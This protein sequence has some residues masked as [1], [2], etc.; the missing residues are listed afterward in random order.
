MTDAVVEPVDAESSISILHLAD[1][2]L[3]M[4]FACRQLDHRD[5]VAL[6]AVCSRFWAISC[7]RE[8]WKRKSLD[9]WRVWR[10][11]AV[12]SGVDWKA[13][14]HR[15]LYWQELLYPIIREVAALNFSRQD[16]SYD[17]MLPVDD[18]LRHR[19][20]DA[21]GNCAVPE[22]LSDTLGEILNS[23]GSDCDLTM[24]YYAGHVRDYVTSFQVEKDTRALCRLPA[25]EIQLEKGAILLS[26][27]QKLSTNVRPD[28]VYKQLDAMANRVHELLILQCDDTENNRHRTLRQQN[29]CCATKIPFEKSSD[30]NS[31][32]VSQSCQMFGVRSVL[33]VLNRVM[34]EEWQ[35]V[36][37]TQD[38]Y[39]PSNSYIDEVI[40]KRTGMPISLCIIY[41]AVAQRLGVRIEP[42]NFPHHFLVRFCESPSNDA[43]VPV[44]V[45]VDVFNAGRFLT[46]AQCVDKFSVAGMHYMSEDLFFVP[47]PQQVFARMV[48]NVLNYYQSAFTMDTSTTIQRLLH[49]LNFIEPDNLQNAILLCTINVHLRVNGRQIID[50]LNSIP[51]MSEEIVTLKEHA[52]VILK[53][54]C[55]LPE[56][57]VKRRANPQHLYVTYRVGLVMRHK[58]YDYICVIYGWDPYCRMSRAWQTQMGVHLLTHKDRQP[59]YSVLVEDLSIRYAAQESLEIA[60]AEAVKPNLHPRVGKYF[61]AFD[62]HRYIPNVE[63][64][65]RYPDDV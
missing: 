33:I 51:S 20:T 6:G 5:V 13:V 48:R 45:Y 28:D 18:I 21:D 50:M 58:R 55:R 22:G 17:T 42:V 30:Y 25:E 27:W 38:Y 11:D 60:P 43:Q 34:F 44:P 56:V 8:L 4:I 47:P 52:D 19:A 29:D 32:Y 39:S 10:F 53:E 63:L 36:G 62:S 61:S 7:S 9:R 24:K 14:F 23:D 26:Q 54:S 35:F 40:E 16:V 49:F 46:A 37:N 15:R 31:C 64:A 12:D 65:K 59:F 1:E 41:A 2:L 3:E 57:V